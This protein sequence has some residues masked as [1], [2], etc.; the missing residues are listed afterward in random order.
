[1]H[2]KEA[3]MKNQNGF[4]TMPA[5][6]RFA[7][8]LFALLGFAAIV[9]G[10]VFHMGFAPGRL[11]LLMAAAAICARAKVKLYKTSTIS[12]LTAVVLLAVIREGLASALIVAVFGVMVQTVVPSK[13]MVLHQLAF[14]FGMIALTVTATWFTH[15]S[16]SSTGAANPLSMEAMATLIA[17]FVY[18]LGNSMSVSLIIGL[19]KKTSIAEVW[20]K[21]F[22]CSAPSFLLAGLLSLGVVAMFTSQSFAIVVA[23]VAVIALGYYS[24]VRLMRTPVVQELGVAK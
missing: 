4:S 8:V 17:S 16:L 24:S 14:N 15:Q 21:H 3:A 23:L 22:T 13:K 12:L 9:Y 19:T 18:F 11:F 10:V 6:A 5:T 2:C 20:L 1:M 7:V